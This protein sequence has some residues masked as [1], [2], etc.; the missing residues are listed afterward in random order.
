MKIVKILD[1]VCGWCRE[2][3]CQKVSMKLPDDETNDQGY[4]PKYVTPA[5]FPLY[6]P[7]KDRLPPGVPAPIPSLCVQLMEGKDEL[8]GKSRRLNIRLCL[9]AWNPGEHGG[10]NFI[11]HPAP[12]KLGGYAYTRWSGPEA[13]DYYRRNA[14]GWRDVWSFVDTAL[15]AVENAEYFAGLRLVKELG[16]TY[17][18]FTEEGAIWDYYPYWH[19]W[20][21]FTLECGI[22]QKTPDAY[23]HLL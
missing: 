1:D 14:E 23:S 11:P 20:I 5:A 3:I 18:P 21:A 9:A 6:L 2:N 15:A 17:G 22:V 13:Q 12:G 7:A 4:E 19:S 16:I 8:I 10:E